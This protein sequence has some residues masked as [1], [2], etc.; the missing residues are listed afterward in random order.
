MGKFYLGH[1]SYNGAGFH[2]WQRQKD[3]RTIQQTIH[4]S[5]RSI[6]EFGRIDVKA[7][8]R[9][10]RGV[11]AFGQVVKMLIPRKEEPEFML[12]QLNKALPADI[13]LGDLV[14]INPSFK[15]TYQALSKEY[16]YFFSTKME[17]VP[18][19]FI[20]HNNSGRP[21][22]IELMRS[23]CQCFVGK[24]DFSRFQ[25]KSDVKGDMVRKVISCDIVPARQLF[26]YFDDESIYC[27][28]IR[29]EGFLKQMVRI[30]M[31]TLVKV[32]LGESSR[33]KVEDGLSLRSDERPG[34]IAPPG[35]LFL[36]EVEYPLLEKGGTREIIDQK[37][38]LDKYPAFELW[39]KGARSF[40]LLYQGES[41]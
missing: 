3:L 14:R 6:Y 36:Y 29:G 9:T 2:G 8:S 18:F 24:H 15:V 25:H 32:G 39:Q 26:T 22:D 30:I 7:T 37:S 4:D 20:G 33:D 38:F 21:M 35:G 5:I 19:S 16:L 13:Y 10:D 31:G 28:R 27:L 34:F 1:I 11:H 17:A 12:E 40:G 41:E 23:V